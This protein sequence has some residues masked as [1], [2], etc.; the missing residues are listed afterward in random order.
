MRIVVAGSRDIKVGEYKTT[1]EYYSLLFPIAEQIIKDSKI[2]ITTIIS[3]G[4]RGIDRCGEI[5]AK[6]YN[7][8]LELYPANWEVHGKSAGYI[9]NRE[10][11]NTAD[12]LI[13]IWDGYSKG[14]K[15]TSSLAKTKGLLIYEK[16]IK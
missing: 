10:M 5:Y 12:G 9:R 16:I 2:D 8:P 3:G 14:S 15:H 7:T 6:K 1:D 4:A 11:V 13:L